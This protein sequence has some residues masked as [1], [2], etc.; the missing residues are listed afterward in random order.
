MGSIIDK[1]KDSFL[2]SDDNTVEFTPLRMIE[3]KCKLQ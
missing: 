3:F 1:F 2:N